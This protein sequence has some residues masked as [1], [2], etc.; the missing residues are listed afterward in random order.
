MMK[1]IIIALLCIV[2]KVTTASAQTDSLSFDE[3]NKYIYYQVATE[4]GLNADT[5]YNRALFFLKTAYPSERLK[6]SKDSKTTGTLTGNGGFMVQKK[7]LV[8]T[9][10]DAKVKFTLVIEVKDNKYRYWFTDLVLVPYQRDRYANFVPV[11]GKDVPLENGYRK[12]GQ[13]DTDDYLEKV[14][15][16]CRSISSKLRTF[17]VNTS[18]TP[19]EIKIKSVTTKEW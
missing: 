17:M 14:L 16:N 19:K 11:L 1:K 12:L 8:S 18:T 4:A 2:V 15:I 10:P 7:A 5:L 3:N 13:K 9:R 6:L